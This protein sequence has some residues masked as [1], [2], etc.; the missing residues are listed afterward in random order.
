MSESQQQ[1]DDQAQSLVTHLTELRDRLLRCVLTILVVFLGL[2]Y[3]ANDIYYF[4]S[5]PLRTLLPEGTS[6]IA[7]E[8]AS[9]FLT[10]FK[11]TLVASVVVAMPVILYQVWGFIAPG[12]YQSERRVAIPLLLSSIVLFYAGLAFAY[13]VVFPLVF[14]FFSGVGPEGVSYTPD[15]AR[16]LDI[17]LKLFFAFGIAFEIPIATL[18]LIW[19]GITTPQ[20]LAEKR[21]YIVV[22]CFVFGMLLTPPDV[23]SQALLAIPMWALFEIG[24]FLGRFIGSEKS[25]STESL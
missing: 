21:P 7:T 10:P 18:L 1:A 17:T 13:Y 25:A 12:M 3:F 8:V 15:I 23:I 6:M 24:V 14:G 11:L 20:A 19:A 5:E 4:V 22:G 2:F 9:P 16:F